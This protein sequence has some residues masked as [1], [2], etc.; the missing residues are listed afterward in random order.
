MKTSQNNPILKTG[1]K[2]F[3][4]GNDESRMPSIDVLTICGFLRHGKSEYATFKEKTKLAEIWP[5]RGFIQ[6]PRWEFE[7]KIPKGLYAG[8]SILVKQ[9]SVFDNQR[10]YFFINKSHAINRIERMAELFVLKHEEIL[11][12]IADY[13]NRI[14]LLKSKEE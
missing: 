6:E 9:I 10:G 7:Q 3:F 2:V 5:S 4:V 8:R 13:K 14:T 12:K 11:S 1:M